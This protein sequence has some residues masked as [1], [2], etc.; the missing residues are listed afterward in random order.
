MI[1]SLRWRLQIYYTALLLSVVAG[2]GSILYVQMRS[3]KLQEIDNQLQAAARI[4]DAKLSRFPRYEL[5]SKD[6]PPL[7]APGFGPKKGPDFWKEKKGPKDKKGP[8]PRDKKGGEFR[9]PPDGAFGPPD[10]KF[11][12]PDGKFGP[13]PI[14]AKER[15][16][17]L[18]ELAL[19]R[20][21][22]GPE[23]ERAY[24]AVWRADKSVL[25]STE[26]PEGIQ[27]PVDHDANPRVAQRGEYREVSL[28]G[29][30]N[31][32]LIVGRTIEK[33]LADLEAFAWQ[34]IGIGAAVLVVGLA[35]GWWLASRI[36]RPI[37]AISAAASA[38]SA[39]NLSTRIEA[40][41]VDVELAGLAQVLNAMFERLEASFERQ[42]QFTADASHELRTPLAILR[43][44]AELAL[45]QARTPEEYRE[46]IEA[47]LRAAER[48]TNLVQGLLTL[49]RADAGNPGVHLH[50]VGLDKVSADCLTAL[51]PLA[52]ERKIALTADLVPATIAGDAN[53]LGQLVANL[54]T[55][56][57]QHNHVGGK[58]HLRLTTANDAA[59]LTVND[60]GPGI[61]DQA[62]PRIFERFFRVDKAR[63]RASGGT[64]LGLA[65][66]KAIAEAHGATIDFDSVE[67]AGATFRVVFPLRKTD[68]RIQ[69]S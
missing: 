49:A 37:A 21:L 56:A 51:K 12:P 13:P 45:S 58:V 34:M 10:G 25:K 14:P 53:S 63:A 20:E 46:T 32:R 65:I 38:I 1:R 47:C 66:C 48:M 29:S 54:V 59:I 23:Q 67:N 31:S 39:T 69:G 7:P 33:E 40:A 24:F 4:L 28:G 18:A 11:G 6:P 43:G 55:N 60:T 30:G 3:S 35:G 2:F 64:G 8:P 15:E 22:A 36:F 68:D 42:Q 57:I 50:P 61:P 9:P 26:L 16:R 52:D 19:P 17:L 27:V 41:N 44:N 5:E 62:R